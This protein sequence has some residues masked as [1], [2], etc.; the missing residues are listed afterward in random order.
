VRKSGLPPSAPEEMSLTTKVPASVPSLRHS[1]RSS[2]SWAAAVKYRMPLRT[3]GESKSVPLAPGVRFL[4]ICVPAAVPSDF[5][6]SR[7]FTP[8]SA[9]K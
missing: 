4:T 1:S 3:T 8:S 6:S 2:E 9:A 5:H 7:P